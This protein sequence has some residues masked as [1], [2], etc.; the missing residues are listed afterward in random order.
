MAERGRP[1]MSADVKAQVWARVKAGESF[2]AIG[3]ALGKPVGSIY[4]VV[5]TQGGIAPAVRHRSVGALT[6]AEREAISRG[7]AA[8]DSLRRIAQQLGRAG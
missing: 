8:G 4:R 6:S 7:L 3:R 2:T 5:R 1:G